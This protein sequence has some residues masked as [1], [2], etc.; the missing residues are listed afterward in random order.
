[1]HAMWVYLGAGK[2]VLQKNNSFATAGI[3]TPNGPVYSQVTKPTDRTST[4]RENY[5]VPSYMEVGTD[6]HEL[7]VIRSLNIFRKARKQQNL[8]S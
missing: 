4:R 8:E 1:M 6:R 2:D 5:I 3:Q 7:T